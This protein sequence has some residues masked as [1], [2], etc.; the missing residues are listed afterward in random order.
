MENGYIVTK[1]GRSGNATATSIAGVFAA[2][3]ATM[4]IAKRSPARRPAIWRLD[5]EAYLEGLA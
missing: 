5:A 1:T 4:S 3:R 2:R